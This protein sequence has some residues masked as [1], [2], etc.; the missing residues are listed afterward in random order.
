MFETL[1]LILFV[2][3]IAFLL[4]KA[5]IASKDYYDYDQKKYRYISRIIK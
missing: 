5:T 3:P 4:F 1:I 2:A